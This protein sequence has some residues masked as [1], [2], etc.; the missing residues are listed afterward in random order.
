MKI[1]VGAGEVVRDGWLSLQQSDLD[2][3]DA[4]QWSRLFAPGSLEAILTEHT[5][6]HLTIAE[7]RAT[8]RNFYRYLKRDGYVRCAVPDGFHTSPEYLNWVAPNSKGEQWLNN[9]RVN[10]PPHKTLWNYKSLSTLFGDAG[11]AVVF[12]EYFDEYGRF[13]KSDWSESDGYIRRASGRAW[14]N[15]LSLWVGAPYTSLL[16][17]A[18]KCST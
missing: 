5:I 1:I 4:R 2:I 12:R 13:H 14:S 16:I 8:V 10:E 18:A 9:F 3:R 15:I 11:F 6:E 17:D 7:A